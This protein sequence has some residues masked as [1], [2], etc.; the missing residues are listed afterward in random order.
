MGD[1]WPVASA[2]CGRSLVQTSVR[3]DVLSGRFCLSA[4]GHK[5]RLPVVTCSSDTASN[6][7]FNGN[8]D[9]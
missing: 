2:D 4:D 1:H 3:L 5:R 6:D 9:L 8:S 7:A